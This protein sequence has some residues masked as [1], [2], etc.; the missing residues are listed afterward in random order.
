MNPSTH[1]A[2]ES[3]VSAHS[4]RVDPF[5]R[6]RFSILFLPSHD[7]LLSL[8]QSQSGG[9]HDGSDDPSRF[10]GVFVICSAP[11]AETCSTVLVHVVAFDP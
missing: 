5:Q 9:C 3:R 4:I 11:S 2:L 10:C 1:P 8:L 7:Y 6:M